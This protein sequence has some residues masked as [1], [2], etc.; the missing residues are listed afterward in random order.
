[1]TVEKVEKEQLT[2]DASRQYPSAAHLLSWGRTHR[3]IGQRVYTP[4]WI[5]DSLPVSVMPLL[6]YGLG[7]SYGDACLNDGG[8][9][10]RTARLDNLVEI[11]PA[12]RTLRCEAG[13]SLTEILARIL[14]LGL[15]IPV[16]PG[17]RH[18]T[19]GGAIANDVHGK[20][21]HREGTFGRH[22][23]ML[24]V[25]RSDGERIVCT[26]DSEA[27]LFRATIGG[28]GLT[29][30]ILRAEIR[31]LAVPGARIEEERLRFKSYD[32]FL[33]LADASDRTHDYTV[34]WADCLS[35][36]ARLGRG[37]FMRGRF[38][39]ESAEG[40]PAY[41]PRRALGCLPFDLPSGVLN[42][43]LVRAFNSTLYLKAGAKPRRRVIHHDDFFYPLDVAD[44]WN[45][46]YGRR[47]FFQ[48]QCVLPREDRETA[49][50]ILRTLARGGGSYLTVIKVF[51]ELAS[52]GLLSFPR[53]GVTFALDLPNR[54]ERTRALLRR[55]EEIAIEAGGALYP[56]KD[57]VMT[58]ASFRRSYPALAE[59]A[60]L[61]DPA[62]SSTFW[63]RVNPA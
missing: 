17:T 38:I 5:T 15:T 8:L 30:L 61:R 55:I 20:N 29:G 18:V 50:Q 28:L 45:R 19:I 46:L 34:A 37:L 62:F 26:P 33:E 22:V 4:H 39:A 21:H 57:A 53:P 2:Q 36:D 12:A 32:E 7:R 9:L 59:F 25:L 54:G 63:R 27:D 47:G 6:P 35:D 16:T 43:A 56:A 60:K 3:P 58:P 24:E 42:A 40:K 52:P 51:G 31:L 49:W 10:I 11:N 1:M 41:R 23:T 48:F 14:P 13:V 44:G